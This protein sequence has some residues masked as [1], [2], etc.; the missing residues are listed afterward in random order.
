MNIDKLKTLTSSRIKALFG[1]TPEVLGEMLIKILPEIE[2]RREEVLK[3]RTD[4]K[5]KYV[6]KDGRPREITALQKVLMSLIY[7]RHNVRHEVVGGMFRYSA[8]SSENAF[9]E[10][11]PILRDMFPSE[12]WE[13]EKKW[14][15]KEEKW[16]PDEVDYGIIDSFETPVSRP[17]IDDKQKKVY[18]G[19]KKEHTL[20]TQII[21][22]QKGEI[23]EINA[24]HDGPKADIKIYK[25]KKVGKPIEGK[26]FLGD[27]AYQSRDHPEIKTPHKKPKG[28]ELSEKQKEENKLLSSLRIKVEHAIRRVKGFGILR[29]DYRLARGLFPMTVSAVVGLIQFS[30]IVAL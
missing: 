5:R 21:T 19:K 22:D 7:L 17:S 24:G 2:R 11:V 23:L 6:A 10:V 3:N 20:K 4:R 25:E 28:G 15:K 29:K 30:Q 26:D 14:S 1:F 12:K 16:T 9:A 8:D 27:K 13:A 18:S